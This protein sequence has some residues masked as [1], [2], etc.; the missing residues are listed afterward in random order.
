MRQNLIDL[1]EFY[2]NLK[3]LSHLKR[4]ARTPSPQIKNKNKS[5]IDR[6]TKV[7]EGVKIPIKLLRLKS[8]RNDLELSHILLKPNQRGVTHLYK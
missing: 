6:N 4:Q 8:N 7:K 3:T 5:N 2:F 1:N